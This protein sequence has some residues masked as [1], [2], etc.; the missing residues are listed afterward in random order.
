[1]RS[2]VYNESRWDRSIYQ[3]FFKKKDHPDGKRKR[4]LLLIV[5]VKLG[6]VW[7][8]VVGIL[9]RLVK[10][11]RGKKTIYYLQ[12]A[13]KTIGFIHVEGCTWT[14][15]GR[16]RHGMVLGIKKEYNLVSGGGV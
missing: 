13:I 7:A 15:E 3:V 10:T 9:Y 4:T 2:F 11:H 8:T 5:R 6:E 14:S 16:L 1:M 12:T